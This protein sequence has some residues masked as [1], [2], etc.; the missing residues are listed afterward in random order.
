MKIVEAE[1]FPDHIHKP[2][3]ISPKMSAP[4]FVGFL[5]GRNSLNVFEK[6]ANLKYQYGNRPF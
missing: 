1:V 5:K 4:S 6:H 2:V 3:E